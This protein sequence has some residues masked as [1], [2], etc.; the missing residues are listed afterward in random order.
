MRSAR[1][2]RL[3]VPDEA[4]LLVQFIHPGGEH[5]PD[6]ETPGIKRWNTGNHQ[7]KFM[8][9]SGQWLDG[10]SPRGGELLFWGEWEPPSEV[11]TLEQSPAGYPKYLHY[12]FLE[13]RTAFGNHQNTDPFVFGDRFLYTG[14]QQWR[15]SY[16]VQLRFLLSGSVILFG[17]ASGG[18][19]LLDTALVVRDYFDH[20]KADH[21]ARLRGLVPDP[22]WTVTLRPWYSGPDDGRSW[23]LYRG[24]SLEDPVDGMFSFFPAIPADGRVARGFPRPDISDLRGVNPRLRQGWQ[25]TKLDGLDDSRAT[26]R[27]VREKVLSQGCIL[28]VSAE[29]PPMRQGQQRIREP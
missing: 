18:R 27:S 23:R 7:R 10:D 8:R 12:P 20:S 28:G 9:S 21:K 6:P 13:A 14:C 3:T 1:P 26:W 2:S 22:Y 4:L 11:D 19:F 24:A 17:S 15:G 29:L 5:G 16:P 25:G